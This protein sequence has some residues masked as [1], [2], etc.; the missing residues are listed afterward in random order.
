[1]GAGAQG[2]GVAVRT[3]AE[4][5]EGLAPV[6]ALQR[7]GGR[8]DHVVVLFPSLSVG[9][10]VEAHYGS[11]L[12]TLEHRFLLMLTML[13]RR[14]GCT[15]IVVVSVPPDPGVWDYYL[16]LSSPPTAATSPS[17]RT[18][19]APMTPP[20]GPWPPRWWTALTCWTGSGA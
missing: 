5:Q 9:P 3:F 19:S 14:P 7:G 8:R 17:G 11:R 10:S 13:R 2:Q 6:L 16:D 12:P 18:W 15:V 4:L 20:H 1:M